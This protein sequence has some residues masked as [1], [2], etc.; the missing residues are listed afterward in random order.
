MSWGMPMLFCGC[1]F[2]FEMYVLPFVLVK[3]LL[4]NFVSSAMIDDDIAG[5]RFGLPFVFSCLIL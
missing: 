1:L 2:L 4:I 3:N 5:R